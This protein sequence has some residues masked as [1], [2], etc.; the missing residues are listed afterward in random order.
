MASDKVVPQL[1]F[2]APVGQVNMDNHGHAHAVLNVAAGPDLH[3]LSPQEVTT[4][5]RA[6]LRDLQGRQ[7]TWT[8]T[9]LG[10]I[11]AELEAVISS[12]TPTKLQQFQHFLGTD[13]GVLLRKYVIENEVVHR[14]VASLVRSWFT[15]G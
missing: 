3:G 7:H 11:N 6:L 5:L 10:D 12:P 2:N 14:T 13:V 1:V 9:A 8:T 15:G 4:A